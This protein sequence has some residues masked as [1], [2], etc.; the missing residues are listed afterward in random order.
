M[1]KQR[2]NGPMGKYIEQYLALRRSLGFLYRVEYTLDAFDQHLANYFP[3]CQTITREIVISYIDST[4]H[5]QPVTRAD[6]V[7][8]LRQFCRFM[9]Q[10][11]PKT[12]IPEKG[13]VGPRKVQV[14]YHIFTEG[15][16]I[17]LIEQAKKIHVNQRNALLPY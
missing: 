15:E 4:R 2:F 10:L 12:Y 14:K 3:D 7:S 9:F 1:K 13:L 16:I 11:D 6:H 17:K 5:N 8:H